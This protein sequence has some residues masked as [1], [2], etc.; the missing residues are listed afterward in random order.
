MYTTSFEYHRANSVREAVD[1]LARYGDDGKLLAGGHSLLPMMKLRFVQPKHLIDVRR[2]P[3]L[4]GIRNESDAIVI[5]ASTTHAAVS[6]SPLVREQLPALSEAAGLI[7]DP[8]VRNMG[9]IGGSLAHADP[10]GDLPAVALALEARLIAVGPRG[11]RVVAAD[12][13]FTGTFTT[14]LSPDE[15]LARI[16]FPIPSGSAGTAYE[17]LP[18]PASGY[19]TVGVAALVIVGGDGAVTRARI[20]ITGLAPIAARRRAVETALVGQQPTEPAIER[21]T[22]HAAEGL[23]LVSDRTASASY[24]ANLARVYTARAV[25]RAAA[26]ARGG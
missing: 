9:T 8:L 2:V 22:Q 14:S 17:K 13:F 3:E 16:Q 5:G 23:E 10:G 6:R 11:E 24:K 4:N 26:R 7:G 25:M 15:V 1:L 12:D 19:A 18:D 20:A 21:A